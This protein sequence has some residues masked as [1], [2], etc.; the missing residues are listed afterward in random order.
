MVRDA[1]YKLIETAEGRDE[2]YD[3]QRDRGEAR[4]LLPNANP[5]QQQIHMRLK[6]A[7][8]EIAAGLEAGARGR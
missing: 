8:A 5:E 1:R 2:L 6:R 4:D 3:L 7:A